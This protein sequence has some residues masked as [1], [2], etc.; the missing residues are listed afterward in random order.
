VSARIQLE[1]VGLEFDEGGNTIWIHGPGG[2][3]LRIKCSGRITVNECS[4][5]CAHADVMVEGD[6][7]FC[8]P[9]DDESATAHETPHQAAQP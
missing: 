8:V 4:A 9:F 6:I 3:V 5:P 1:A 2:T 7:A